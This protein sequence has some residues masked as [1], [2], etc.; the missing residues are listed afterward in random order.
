MHKRKNEK[1]INGI[2]DYIQEY[3]SKND[4]LRLNYDHFRRAVEEGNVIKN[5]ASLEFEDL[6]DVPVDA[7]TSSKD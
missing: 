4:R 6:F 5:V 7:A 1:L 2:K 3:R